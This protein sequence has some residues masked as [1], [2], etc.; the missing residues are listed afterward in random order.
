MRSVFAA[1]VLALGLANLAGCANP[2]DIG[3]QVFGSVTVHCVRFSDGS[4]VPGANVS[5][6][7]L[8]ST[9]DSSGSATFTQV[10]VGPQTIIARATGLYGTQSITVVQGTNPDV[11]IQMRA[12]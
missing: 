7:N 12:Q 6:S 9:T 8:A 1:S 5:L 11:T 10:S 3:V 4:P 2:N